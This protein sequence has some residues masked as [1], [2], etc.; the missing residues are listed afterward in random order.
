MPA[1]WSTA[2]CVGDL[3]VANLGSFAV[4][5]N[6]G[7][8]SSR[9][10]SQWP[11][12]AG[13]RV[14]NGGGDL[15]VQLL[16]GTRR[17]ADGRATSRNGARVYLADGCG[18][19]AEGDY[20]AVRYAAVPLLGRTLSVSVDL[21]GVECGCNGALYL[22]S[23]AGA[24]RPG[25]CGGDFYCDANNVCG[26]ECV[27]IGAAPLSVPRS[28]PRHTRTRTR[29]VTTQTPAATHET[30]ARNTTAPPRTLPALHTRAPA[31]TDLIEAN[32]HAFRATAHTATDGG[33]KGNGLGGGKH[34]FS[35][36]QYGP[37][38]SAIDT[39]EPFAVDATFE[40]DASSS[41]HGGGRGGGG[42]P[43]LGGITITL[44]Q[45]RRSLSF[46]MAS[47]AYLRRVSDA[48]V[49]GLTPVAS[50]WSSSD[51]SWLHSGL[52][53]HADQAACA[54]SIAF[55]D[56][57]LTPGV[58]SAGAPL[59]SPLPPSPPPPP[60]S[61]PPPP[62]PPPLPPPPPP[63]PSPSPPP[64][65]PVA[66]Q[67][68]KEPPPPP[69][70]SPHPPSPVSP[71]PPPPPPPSPSPPLRPRPPPPPPPHPPP[72]PP[73]P[74]PSPQ[75]PP[76]AASAAAAAAAQPP[77]PLPPPPPPWPPPPPP[78]PA[79]PPRRRYRTSPPPPQPPDP[80]SHDT[81]PADE[82]H[83]EG[84]C[85]M[86][87][88]DGACLSRAAASAAS[89][90]EGATADTTA[91]RGNAATAAAATAA[92]R[93]HLRGHLDAANSGAA[94]SALALLAACVCGVASRAQA[95]QRRKRMAKGAA[96]R[97]PSGA[98]CDTADARDPEEEGQG[99]GVGEGAHHPLRAQPRPIAP[100]A[101]RGGT[102]TSTTAVAAMPTHGAPRA[103]AP[104][105]PPASLQELGDMAS[106][107]GG[108]EFGSQPH[109]GQRRKGGGGGRRGGGT[110][111]LLDDDGAQHKDGEGAVGAGDDGAL[112][113]GLHAKWVDELD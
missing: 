35:A 112:H 57:R 60:S 63:S 88:S 71:S 66:T 76:P 13:A 42:A 64:P 93:S 91:A 26:V 96:Q 92:T 1:E 85:R 59:P 58:A 70:P 46:S 16:P 37:G 2:T 40:A 20:A 79:P 83:D 62:S 110:T 98:A 90:A 19:G 39:N 80:S 11:E 84:P 95:A 32:K 75:P 68:A 34:A 94:V 97:V 72:P 111:R 43:R 28:L 38:A 6:P 102:T 101:G 52:G 47:S 27:E 3:R 12:A 15:E 77:S 108:T 21:S 89:T 9:C 99:E 44:R 51:M 82:G 30:R 8:G 69:S 22:V 107:I 18:G 54:D 65:S 23:M 10:C 104:A 87:G 7:G 100:V 4:V 86:L 5:R 103:I 50:Y 17:T 31:P 81:A 113:M 53:C 55:T 109:E 33:G 45:R 74:Q 61:S 67:Q 25:H 78:H 14:S 49:A 56:W 48:V 41:S 105:A 24:A 106:K 73:R 29:R 36:A